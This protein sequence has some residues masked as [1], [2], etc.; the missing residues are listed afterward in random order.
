VRDTQADRLG[1]RPPRTA[2]PLCDRTAPANDDADLSRSC[3]HGRTI[4]SRLGI[5][6]AA[7]CGPA[8]FLAFPVH[9]G[10]CT[11]EIIQFERTLPPETTGSTNRQ[12]EPA[13]PKAAHRESAGEAALARARRFDA[14]GR[15]AEC[16]N[17]LAEARRLSR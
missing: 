4:M 17:A 9:A 1:H 5:V 8:A 3:G 12:A 10:P 2:D 16:L 7:A 6:V 13:K 11:E 14:E 15:R